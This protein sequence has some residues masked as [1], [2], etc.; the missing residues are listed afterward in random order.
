MARVPW[1]LVLAWGL[2]G[3]KVLLSGGPEDRALRILRDHRVRVEAPSVVPRAE[4]G[5]PAERAPKAPGKM[6]L[7]LERAFALAIEGNRD[8]L[9]RE[10]DLR[11][12]ALALAAAAYE[13][14]PQLETTVSYL[15]TDAERGG[16]RG[17][18]RGAVGGGITQKLPLGG[19][20]SLRGDTTAFTHHAD[21]TDRSATTGYSL[22]WN[23]PLLRGFGPTAAMDGLIQARRELLY[24]LRAFERERQSFAIDTLSR[25]F[26]LVRMADQLANSERNVETY[27]GQHLQAQALFAVDRVPEIDV[28]RAEREAEQAGND[29]EIARDR[30]AAALD[31]FKVFLGLDPSTDLTLQAPA[32][33]TRA[34]AGSPA[35]EGPDRFPF[36]LAECARAALANRLDLKTLRD[37]LEDA[38]RAVALA[39][40]GL[41][42]DLR[43]SLGARLDHPAV[44]D[45]NDQAFEDLRPEHD[46]LFRARVAEKRAKRAAELLEEQIRQEV[47][48]LWRS[49][50]QARTTLRVQAKIRV[51][52]EKR[53][54]IAKFR[55]QAGEIG[56]RDV[57]EATEALLQAENQTIEAVVDRRRSDLQLAQAMGI[58]AVRPDGRPEILGWPPDEAEDAPGPGGGGS[59]G[60]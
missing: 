55:F 39:G 24:A 14:E 10:E 42:P 53:L 47:R 21:K 58:L 5:T 37:R 8:F 45:Y 57:M 20:L 34:R 36:A 17:A 6:D 1:I 50:N 60:R 2:A 30:H 9:G 27:R 56:N 29:L 59:E 16:A 48:E 43:F 32:W 51:S 25:F 41:L 54:E 7:T 35:G 46:A 4:P 49:A 19:S 40:N 26:D 18:S 13:W 22:S 38:R 12:A 52:A 15:L 31:A 11:L 44:Q 33:V 23:Q 28:L 3:C